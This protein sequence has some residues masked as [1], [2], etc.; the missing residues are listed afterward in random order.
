MSVLRA[1][2][3]AFAIESTNERARKKTNQ[4]ARE[5]VGCSNKELH[6]TECVQNDR[7]SCAKCTQIQYCFAIYLVCCT[8]RVRSRMFHTHTQYIR[9]HG[10]C[11]DSAS[12]RASGRQ[13]H[14]DEER[15]NLCVDSYC[16][17]TQ[18][19]IHRTDY[20]I[21]CVR[22]LLLLLYTLLSFKCSKSD[23]ICTICM[24]NSNTHTGSDSESKWTGIS[25]ADAV[26]GA[27]A[28]ESILLQILS[29]H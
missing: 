17:R 1:P 9:A 28:T 6:W 23:L 21:M 14:S 5:K 18:Q 3:F 8:F 25:T 29:E 26:A 27:R 4:Q 2:M 15:E 20:K 19:D 7:W 16:C 11:N 22:I 13:R 24:W 10:V 12:E